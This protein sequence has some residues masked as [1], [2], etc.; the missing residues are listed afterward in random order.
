MFTVEI[1]NI[2]I[3]ANIGITSKERAKKQILKVTLS[4]S[5][6]VNKKKDLDKISNVKDYSKITKY[7]KKIITDSRF[8][9]LEKLIDSTNKKLKK[10][11]KL[12]N[13]KIKINKTAV[14]KKYGSESLSVSN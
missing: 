3:P 4:F 7:L 10:E 2:S 14:A 13:I 5:Y 8:N 12:K 9:T 11:F 6:I 1:K